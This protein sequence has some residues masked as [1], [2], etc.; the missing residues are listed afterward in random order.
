[1]ST[2]SDAPAAVPAG[3][4]G[5]GGSRL[6]A[7]LAR[8]SRAE[9]L[10]WAG[11]T[12]GVLA[13]YITLPPLLVRT[14]VPSLVLAAGG[15]GL[16]VV[17]LRAG[18]R[19]VGWGAVVAC[20]AGAFGAYGAVKSG[21]GNLERVVVWS[22]LLA[23]ALR[24]ATPL[25][26]AALGGVTSERAGVVNIGLEGMMLTGAFFGAWGADI[27]SSWVGGIV[28]GLV[29]GGL[30]GL[31][32]AVFSVSLR[33]DQIVSGTAINFLA[34]GITGYLFIKI[35]GTE[36]T[37][38]DLPEIPD[39]HLP[40][41]WIPFIGEGLEQLNLMVW[42]GLIAVAALSLFLFRTPRGLRLRSVGENPL[43]ADTAGISPI[44]VRYYAVMASGAFAAL[45]GVFL[46]IG[47]VHSFGQNMTAGKGF[48]GLAAVI[49][50]KWKPGGAL[51][52]ALLFGFSSALAQ[53]LDV[54][55][56]STAVLFQ[57]LPYVLTLIAVAGLVGRSR[58]PAADGIPYERH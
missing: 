14:I 40:I 55:N 17:A 46:S 19:R 20:V 12:L 8:V 32:H 23:A 26:F 11:V 3:P 56:P 50:G 51:A 48:I 29:A 44:R 35:Y 42:I 6:R 4:G 37:P 39:V 58:P 10:G 41:G 34:L 27:T 9:W 47:F 33:A 31:L 22:A 43:A 7:R 38:D 30:L 5:T 2:T 36:G 52:A 45:G 18:E 28:I 16:G 57:A 49:F 21:V 13:F 15:I 24:Y 1:M 54:F 25:T 53:R